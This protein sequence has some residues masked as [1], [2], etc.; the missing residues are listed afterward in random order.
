[1]VAQVEPQDPAKAETQLK[2]WLNALL[3]ELLQL[4]KSR[5]IEL[6]PS[7]ATTRRAVELFL[8]QL[9]EHLD[10]HWTLEKM[11]RH[12]GLGRSRFAYYCEEITNLSPARYLMRCR[13]EQAATRLKER[14]EQSITDVALGCGFGSSQYFANAFRRAYGVTPSALREVST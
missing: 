10:Y 12:C 1:V 8:E 11:A 14:R 4:L 6:H 13:L 2:I 9:P 7:L 5:K 3:F